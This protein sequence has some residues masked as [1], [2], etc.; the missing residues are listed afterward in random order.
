MAKG[1]G[2]VLGF[3]RV[4]A[5]VD[6]VVVTMDGSIRR[7]VGS[8]KALGNAAQGFD[9]TEEGIR[10]GAVADLFTVDSILLVSEG[11]RGHG[12]GVES[13]VVIQRSC[14]TGV[15]KAIDGESDVTEEEGLRPGIWIGGFQVLSW[16]EEPVEGDNDEVD[17]VSV[18]GPI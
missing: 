9:R 11:Q 18:E 10:V 14:W 6:R 12:D 17:G 13:F 8:L 5:A 7:S 1:V 3:D 15:G 16:A 2:D 4:P